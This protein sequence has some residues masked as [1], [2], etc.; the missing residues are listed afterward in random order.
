MSLAPDG[1]R[2]STRNLRIVDG[3]RRDW[4]GGYTVEYGDLIVAGPFAAK[5]DAQAA[6]VALIAG[7]PP[8]YAER[9][10]ARAAR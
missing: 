10:R 3:N 9:Y 7:E 2:Y 4:D 6:K 1:R 8:S 5:V